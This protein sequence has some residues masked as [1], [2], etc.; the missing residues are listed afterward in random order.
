MF[1]SS[2]LIYNNGLSAINIFKIKRIY[3]TI[4]EC[5]YYINVDD[6][7]IYSYKAIPNGEVIARE[8]ISML[9]NHIKFDAKS[10]FDV[11]ENFN[12]YIKVK[13]I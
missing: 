7:T 4:G 12:K 11:D 10:H 9:L 5:E 8:L 6:E 3:L 13:G 2:Y 1:E